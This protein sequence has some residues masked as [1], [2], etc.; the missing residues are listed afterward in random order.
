VLED[1]AQG[2][3]RQGERGVGRGMWVSGQQ[4]V[5]G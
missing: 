4:V 5:D 1:A 2:H 3:L